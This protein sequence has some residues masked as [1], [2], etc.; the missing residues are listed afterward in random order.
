MAQPVPFPRRRYYPPGVAGAIGLLLNLSRQTAL[1]AQLLNPEHILWGF[2]ALG[3][4][5][6][7]FLSADLSTPSS[8]LRRWIRYR[9]RLFDVRSVFPLYE[10]SR[11]RDYLM[12]VFGCRAPR[13]CDGDPSAEELRR[14]DST[15]H[16]YRFGAK[17]DPG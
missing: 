1:G 9:T 17:S 15:R 14:A 10:S 13:W 3:G 5:F 6:V 11:N 7:G 12:V 8:A 4:I 2:L 16:R